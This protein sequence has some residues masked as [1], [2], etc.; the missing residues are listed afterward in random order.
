MY[1]MKDYMYKINSFFDKY[2][3]ISLSVVVL[4]Q[5]LILVCLFYNFGIQY[6]F[7]TSS[8]VYPAKTLL[9]KGIM[10]DENN[11]PILFRT[12]GYPL[13]ISLFYL[14]FGENFVPL[15]ILQILMS[16]LITMMI[17]YIVSTYINKAAGI[18]ACILYLSDSAEYNYVT[19]ILTDLPFSFLVTLSLFLLIR[20]I[21]NKR[22]YNYILACVVINFAM[23]VRPNIMYFNMLLAVVLVVFAILK[24]VNWKKVVIYV[25]MFVVVY[26]GWSTRN[27]YYYGEMMFTS[28]RDES[29]FQ[30]YAPLMYQK[31][32][33]CSSKEAY[34]YMNNMLYSKYPDVDSMSE[35]ERVKA[36]ND[37]GTTYIKG[38]F[39]YYIYMNVEGLIKEMFSPGVNESL[40]LSGIV[41]Y[42]IKLFVGGTLVITYLIYAT[43]FFVNIKKW[44][45]L[46][47]L[48]LI[49][50]MY[51]MASTAVLGYSRFRLAFY[52]IC[53]V[54]A[55]LSWR[56]Q[57]DK[58]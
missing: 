36:Y 54:G 31:E 22:K 1:K 26:G 21:K 9:D 57:I 7:D 30:F 51:F 20:Y 8:Y 56:Q 12:P 33:N 43:G 41:R 18:V 38:H 28:I 50:T 19:C 13:I 32:H 55:F 2:W 17:F 29:T 52:P 25:S 49:L 42:I 58:L 3:K 47:W 16:V 14:I 4:F 48:I 6:A 45:W 27:M 23:L 44:K 11:N 46:D 10:L 37:I 40:Q 53:I 34:D 5:L 35:I 24:K 15:I 39:K